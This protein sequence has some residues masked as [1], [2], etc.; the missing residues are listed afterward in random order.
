LKSAKL[1]GS[2]SPSRVLALRATGV[3]NSVIIAQMAN[4]A[5]LKAISC[6]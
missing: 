6:D 2:F 5:C 4:H 1:S 3:R